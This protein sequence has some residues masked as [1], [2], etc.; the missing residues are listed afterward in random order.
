[1]SSSYGRGAIQNATELVSYIIVK[2]IFSSLMI[3]LHPSA[4]GGGRGVAQGDWIINYVWQLLKFSLLI[5][6]TNLLIFPA[7]MFSQDSGDRS[8]CSWKMMHTF[9]I[10]TSFAAGFLTKMRFIDIAFV[11]ER[12]IYLHAVFN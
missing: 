8:S 7:S 1:M 2:I 10:V 3:N 11:L 12:L 9:L 5:L 4:R 6:S